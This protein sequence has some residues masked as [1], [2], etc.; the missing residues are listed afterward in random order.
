MTTVKAIEPFDQLTLNLGYVTASLSAS[1]YS[2]AV[3]LAEWADNQLLLKCP[4]PG[5]LQTTRPLSM[6]GWDFYFFIKVPNFGS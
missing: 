2:F 5:A 1:V 6:F 4:I 3:R